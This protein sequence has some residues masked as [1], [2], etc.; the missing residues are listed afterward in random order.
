MRVMDAFL[1]QCEVTNGTFYS[2]DSFLMSGSS[3]QGET[4]RH[5]C[6]A[7]LMAG[8]FSHFGTMG[9][10]S[11]PMFLPTEGLSRPPVL[12]TAPEFGIAIQADCWRRFT[13]TAQC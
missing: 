2:Q 8:S 4:G 13:M 12:T 1:L 9:T 5:G 3:P 11:S 6:G 10:W 7:V